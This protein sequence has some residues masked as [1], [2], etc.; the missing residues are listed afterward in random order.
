MSEKSEAEKEI[1]GET[2]VIPGPQTSIQEI[3][4]GMF[5]LIMTLV[6][7]Y[8]VN[9]G[10]SKEISANKTAEVLERFAKVLRSSSTNQ[11]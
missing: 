4:I 8:K 3:E 7:H 2:E 1:D 6:N 11:Q 5:S 10:F 9:L